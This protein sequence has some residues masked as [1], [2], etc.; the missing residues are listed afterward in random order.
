METLSIRFQENIMKKIDSVIKSNFFNSRTEFVREAVRDKLSELEKEWAI[1]EF[2]KLHGSIK[3]KTNKTDRQ[4]REQ[5]SK[6]MLA[7]LEKKFG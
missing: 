5:V 4:I 7:E 3:R 1:N 2:L 6:E